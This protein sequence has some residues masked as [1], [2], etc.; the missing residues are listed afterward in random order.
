MPRFSRDKQQRCFCWRG[1][2]Q[3]PSCPAGPLE[4]DTVATMA[5][6]VWRKQNLSTYRLA[7]LAKS[8]ISAIRGNF[9]PQRKFGAPLAPDTRDPEEVKAAEKAADEQA[10]KELGQ[11]HELVRLGDVATIEYLQN[12]LLLIDRLDGMIA[13]CIKR[14]L[15]VAG[16]KSL[17]SGSSTDTTGPKRIAAS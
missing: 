17:S 15:M 7:D 3:C 2:T 4:Q 9:V 8:R 13:R 12:E 16:L 14:L 1:R 5:R 10:R 11:F 6:L